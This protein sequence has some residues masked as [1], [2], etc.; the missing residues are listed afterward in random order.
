MAISPE[1]DMHVQTPANRL[2]AYAA[3]LLLLLVGINADAGE[4]AS[5]NAFLSLGLMRMAT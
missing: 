2:S 4:G 1:V 3:L 5:S